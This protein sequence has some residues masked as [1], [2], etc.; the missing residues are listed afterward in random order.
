MDLCWLIGVAAVMTLLT[1][2]SESQ[3]SV[4]GLAPLNTRIVGGQDAPPGSWPWQ[5]SLTL[6]RYHICGGSL[7]NNQWVL[8]AAQCLGFPT[9]L[10]QFL[11]VNLGR[12]SQ[13]GPNPN[14]VTLPLAGF[15]VHP[16]YNNKDGNNDIALLKLIRPVDFTSFIAPVCIAASNSTFFSG[17]NGWVTGWG[18]IKF[19]VPPPSS[20]NL[21]EVEVPVVGNTECKCSYGDLI[22][23]NMM[24][25]GLRTGGKGP[26]QGDGG[27]PL[28]IKQDNRW[29]LAGIPI[30]GVGCAKPNFPTVYTRVSQY[31][32]WINS[33]VSINKPGFINFSSPGNNSD[34]N[35][36][37]P[38]L[39]TTFTPTNLTAVPTATMKPT[40]SIKFNG[41]T[42]ANSPF[43]S[44]LSLLILTFWLQLLS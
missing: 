35:F 14:E 30:F 19:G 27:G 21:S 43:F 5:V 40:N 37:C 2:E 36:T 12:Q 44:C 13:Q 4:C 9:F 39:T 17:V 16:K 31:E 42:P 10:L 32:T 38:V 26:C 22:T 23:D 7:I 15:V 28:V 25:A 18:N 8:T 20:Q 3:L 29:I 34:L 41:N 24:C 33:F 1:R 11:T 6:G